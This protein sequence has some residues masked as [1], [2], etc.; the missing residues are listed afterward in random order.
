[1]EL[2]T[3]SLPMLTFCVNGR[4]RKIQQG[5]SQAEPVS[6]GIVKPRP[7]HRFGLDAKE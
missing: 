5:G 4:S 3:G 2:F 6:D 7:H 1:M